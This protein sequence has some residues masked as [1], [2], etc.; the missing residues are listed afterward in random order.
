M[1]KQ[2][3]IIMKTFVL[4]VY[5]LDR[6]PGDMQKTDMEIYISVRKSSVANLGSLLFDMEIKDTNISA[7]TLVVLKRKIS[8]F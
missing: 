1:T 5:G 2:N 7:K 8:I 4:N 6:Y 3:H